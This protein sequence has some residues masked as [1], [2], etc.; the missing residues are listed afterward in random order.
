M[1]RISFRQIFGVQGLSVKRIPVSHGPCCT[2]QRCGYSHDDCRCQ[3]NALVEICECMEQLQ[4]K[5]AAEQEKN[6]W[7]HDALEVCEGCGNTTK[8]DDENYLLWCKTCWE[9]VVFENKGL[10]KTIVA[11]R[12]ILLAAEKQRWIPVT[13]RLP[14]PTENTHPQQSEVVKL[15]TIVEVNAWYEDCDKHWHDIKTGKVIEGTHWRPIN[16]PVE[17]DGKGVG[18]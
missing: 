3:E 14:K 16:L 2:C 18:K 9:K 17:P 11:A 13:E 12:D 15:A 1:K 5:L 4:S 8:I 6:K 7:L 10:Q